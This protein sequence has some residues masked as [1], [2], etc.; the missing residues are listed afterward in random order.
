MYSPIKKL[1]REKGL[2]QVQLAQEL[3][4]DQTSVSKWESGKANPTKEYEDKL[5]E[6]FGVSVEV[7]MGLESHEHFPLRI[8]GDALGMGLPDAYINLLSEYST[9]HNF[10]RMVK[11][12]D[13]LT[14]MQRMELI[15]F[16]QGMAGREPTME[17]GKDDEDN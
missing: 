11:L 15:G 2:T 13:N 5:V 8:L 10:R 12:W 14:E 17:G 6:F 3:G 1:R 16:A 4:V 7:L 9:C